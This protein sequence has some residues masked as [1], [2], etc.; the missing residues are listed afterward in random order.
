MTPFPYDA[1][2][3]LL[4]EVPPALGIVVEADRGPLPFALI[5]GEALVACAAWALGEAEVAILD[6]TVPWDDVRAADEPLVLHDALCPMTPPGFVVDCVRRA[7]AADVVVA[8]VRPVTD[9]VK[10]VTD[11]L[12]GATVDR[13][14]LVALASPVV[15]PARV[16]RELAHAP[17]TDLAAL[18]QALSEGPL[19]EVELVEAPPEGRRV[20]SEDEV[21]LLE[22]LTDR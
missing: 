14:G 10:Q 3:D 1:S 17:G 6:A 16:V 20:A 11:G 13:E 5:H 9:T 18:V 21:R 7:V 15:L 19:V 2:G 22:G 4:P 8:G 12:V